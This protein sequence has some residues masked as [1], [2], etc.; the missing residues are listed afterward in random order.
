MSVSHNLP[1][2]PAISTQNQRL[3]L[4]PLN[5]NIPFTPFDPL[6]HKIAI[7]NTR[8]RKLLEEYNLSNYQRPTKAHR[9]ST[10]CGRK[11]P[12]P[13]WLKQNIHWLQDGER[14][15]AVAEGMIPWK[16]DP[17]VR[18]Y[19]RGATLQDAA[20]EFNIPLTTIEGWWKNRDSI[21]AAHSQRRRLQNGNNGVVLHQKLETVTLYPII[22]ARIVA[23]QSISTTYVRRQA[24][25][26]YPIIYHDEIRTRNMPAEFHPTNYWIRGFFSPSQH[27]TA[28][29]N[30]CCSKTTI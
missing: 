9:I 21:H 1:V 20:D 5:P 7:T 12:I 11:R 4:Q 15:N 16:W 17:T 19:Y 10:S 14:M 23:G 29:S 8:K 2:L 22:L 6:V 28:S 26:W 27:C 3:P 18:E 30:A 25:K 24:K 13:A